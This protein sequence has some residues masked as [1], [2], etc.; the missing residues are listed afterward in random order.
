MIPTQLGT[1]DGGEE[2]ARHL[3]QVWRIFH[4]MMT[5]L[6]PNSA[7]IIE[8]MHSH[9]G[10]VAGKKNGVGFLSVSVID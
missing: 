5:D 1:S 7:I 10:A 8:T 6:E 3:L 2:S 9:K 4:E